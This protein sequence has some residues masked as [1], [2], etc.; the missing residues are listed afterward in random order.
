MTDPVLI[1]MP[2]TAL[3]WQTP[4]HPA[5]LRDTLHPLKDAPAGAPVCVE[6]TLYE[7]EP[8]TACRLPHLGLSDG[9][10]GMTYRPPHLV[11]DPEIA[12]AMLLAITD[13]RLHAALEAMKP[14]GLRPGPRGALTITLT[15]RAL[16]A[17]PAGPDEI[18]YY[19]DNHEVFTS[20]TIH[21]LALLVLPKGLSQHEKIEMLPELDILLTGLAREM[22]KE[23]PDHHPVAFAVERIFRRGDAA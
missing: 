14:G 13:P 23:A 10:G 7:D 2:V 21:N 6:F 15:R 17:G 19:L 18:D 3:D 11:E 22:M 1:D 4:E 16:L 5:R 8:T 12:R 9:Q 20:A